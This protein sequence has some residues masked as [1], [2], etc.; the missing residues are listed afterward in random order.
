M[1]I[2]SIIFQYRYLLVD[3]GKSEV[4]QQPFALTVAIFE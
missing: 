2:Y 3:G 4:S 1:K